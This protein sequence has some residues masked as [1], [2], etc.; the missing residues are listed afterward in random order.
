[1]ESLLL[2]ASAVAVL[3]GLGGLVYGNWLWLRPPGRKPRQP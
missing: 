2:G 3:V 1:M